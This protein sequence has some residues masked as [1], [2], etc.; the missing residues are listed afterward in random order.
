M[1]GNFECFT[2]GADVTNW[3]GGYWV[4]RISSKRGYIPGNVRPCCWGC[5]NFKSNKNPESADQVIQFHVNKYG[6]GNVPWDE[7]NP[8]IKHTAETVPDLSEYVTEPPVSQLVL[9]GAA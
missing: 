6:R 7:I 9:F 1:M 5:N 2:C 4:D 3:G 8:Q